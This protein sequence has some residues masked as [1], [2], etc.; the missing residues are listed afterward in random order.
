MRFV[1]LPSALLFNEVKYIA[2]PVD[3]QNLENSLKGRL[4]VVFAYVPAIGTAGTTVSHLVSFPVSRILLWLY[5]TESLTQSDIPAQNQK[6]R[7]GTPTAHLGH[8]LE[9]GSDAPRQSLADILLGFTVKTIS[10]TMNILQTGLQIKW[11]NR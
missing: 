9:A 11:V 3:H 4:N 7:E 5:R 8:S 10:L 1:C 6:Y 2:S